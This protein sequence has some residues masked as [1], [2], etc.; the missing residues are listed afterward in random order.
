MTVGTEK[1]KM[2]NF[3]KK[4]SFWLTS[5]L[6][7]GA[8]IWLIIGWKDMDMVIKLPIIYIVALA[9]HEIEELKFP[10][11]FVELVLAM[12]G[13]EI[14]NIGIAKFGLLMFTL[15]ATV[16]PAVI[17]GYIWPVMATLF[18]GCIEIFAHLAA[19]RV[20]PERFYSPGLIT[21]V[22]VQF[23]VAVYGY[24]YLFANGYV[25][26]IYWLWAAIFLLVPLFG[27]QAVIVKS[28]GESYGEFMNNAR[29]AMF[30]KKG[31]EETKK[32]INPLQK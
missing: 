4:Y 11:G 23:P 24:Y 32:K 30:T 18:I 26:G 10:G 7:A 6:G 9:V 1:N 21:A 29:K 5:L 14:R 28:N 17:G 19:A 8:I 15:Y 2:E 13:I 25:K 31:R 27:L 22:C 12:T 3:M 16:I 20:N